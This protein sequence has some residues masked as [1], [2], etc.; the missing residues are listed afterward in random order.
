MSYIAAKQLPIDRGHQGRLGNWRP[1]PE[2]WLNTAAVGMF[3][4]VLWFLN[5]VYKE[6]EQLIAE[7]RGAQANPGKNYYVKF[8]GE[9]MVYGPHALKSAKSFA[10]IGSQTGRDRIVYRG[11]PRKGGKRVRRYSGGER[12]WP[13]TPAQVSGLLP[14]EVP[15]KLSFGKGG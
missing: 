13:T 5:K 10:R 7:R 8:S 11:Y 12:V 6:H 4:G 2:F 14:A 15:R 9:P 1:G 3:V